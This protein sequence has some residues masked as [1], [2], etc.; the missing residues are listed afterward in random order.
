MLQLVAPEKNNLAINGRNDLNTILVMYT[1]F[2]AIPSFPVFIQVHDHGKLPAII[3][4]ETIYVF[5]VKS[6]FVI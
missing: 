3:I 4:L 2:P 1:K 5:F 6:S